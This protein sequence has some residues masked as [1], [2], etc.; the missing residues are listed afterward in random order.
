M[1]ILQANCMGNLLKSRFRGRTSNSLGPNLWEWAP[2][3]LFLKNLHTILI[4]PKIWDIYPHNILVLDSI[5]NIFYSVDSIALTNE[6]M[7]PQ[8]NLTINSYS[9]ALCWNRGS[10]ATSMHIC[11]KKK[12]I[13]RT[14]DE[15]DDFNYECPY[16]LIIHLYEILSRPT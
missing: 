4:C 13:L 9:I 6:I 1:V 2:N 3:S 14:W 5:Q 7:H 10:F 16:S 15:L 11:Q 8:I 12:K